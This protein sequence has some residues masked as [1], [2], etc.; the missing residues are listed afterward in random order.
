VS[1]EREESDSLVRVE[2]RSGR[3]EEFDISKLRAS[4]TK[5]GASDEQATRIAETIAGSVTEGTDTAQLM[6]QAASELR[7]ADPT[8][9][10]RYECYTTDAYS[11]CPRCGKTMDT[12]TQSKT[13]VCTGCGTTAQLP[14]K[15]VSV[16]AFSR[17]SSSKQEYSI[18]M[19]CGAKNLGNT[20]LCK[21]C[22]SAR[23]HEIPTIY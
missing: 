7:R 10:A 21:N 4:L 11:F 14:S 22:H 18:C 8:A 12:D 2:K 15:S 3:L 5:A 13:A 6:L 23:P 20:R 9:A 19:R 17:T 1:L 16:P